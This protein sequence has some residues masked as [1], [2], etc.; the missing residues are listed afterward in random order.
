MTPLGH[1]QKCHMSPETARAEG[2]RALRAPTFPFLY[3]R[4]KKLREMGMKEMINALIT[5]ERTLLVIIGLAFLWRIFI[6]LDYTITMGESVAS[7]IALIGVGWL[8]FAHLYSLPKKQR[9]G[10]EVVK[11]YQGIALGVLAINIYVLVYYGMRWYRLSGLGSVAE[12]FVPLDFMFRDIR[13]FVLVAFYC[14]SIV[15]SKFL[16]RAYDEFTLLSPGASG[17]AARK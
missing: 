2:T 16:K 14:A 4:G 1:P 5:D 8:F 13:F 10:V 3:T 6:S 15:L 7:G 11:V 12:A 9:E 17:K